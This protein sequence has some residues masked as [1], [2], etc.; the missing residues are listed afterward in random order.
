MLCQYKDKNNNQCKNA[1]I[2]NASFCHLRS[3]HADLTMYQQTIQNIRNQFES[4]TIPIDDF[5]IHNIT[6]DGACAFRCMIRSLYDVKQFNTLVVNHDSDY[7]QKFIE[8]INEHSK[9]SIPVETE[10]ATIIQQMIREWII[11][12]KD[13]MDKYGYHL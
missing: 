5:K 9:L 13:M 6:S 1:I 7:S 3:H 4:S 10:L 8:L 12:N 2:G 11:K